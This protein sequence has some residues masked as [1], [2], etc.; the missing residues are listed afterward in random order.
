[1]KK[2]PDRYFVLDFF[3]G[4]GSLDRVNI[5]EEPSHMLAT[6]MAFS[7][8]QQMIEDSGEIPE[9]IEVFVGSKSRLDSYLNSKKAR[10]DSFKKGGK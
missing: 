6:V 10:Q 7:M 8:C 2:S 5:F 3:K 1:M 9:R 4:K